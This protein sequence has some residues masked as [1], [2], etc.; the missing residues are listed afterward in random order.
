MGETP[1]LFRSVI[2]LSCNGSNK[3]GISVMAALVV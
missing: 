2:P 3:P 1:I